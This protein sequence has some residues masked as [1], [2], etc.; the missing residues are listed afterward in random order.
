MVPCHVVN[1]ET[2][3]GVLLHGLWF[4]PKKPK[5]AIVWVHGLT[6]SA[7]AR[8]ELLHRL[9]ES[10]IGVLS[11]NNRGNGVVS[12]IRRK[13][14]P[15]L[16]IG[17]AREKFVD[18]V[19]DIDG[20]IRF[21]RCQGVKRIFLAG[22]STGCQ[23][24]V[25]WAAK[26]SGGK[27]AKGIILLAPVNDYAAEIKLQGK[28]RIAKAARTA[29]EMVRRGKSHEFLPAGVWYE[30]LE[31]QRFLSLYTSGTA[32]DVFPY[33]TTGAVPQFL[34]MVRAPMLAFF[35]ENEE[36]AD[37]PATVLKE[38]FEAQSARLKGVIVPSVGHSFK[39]GERAIVREIRRFV[40]KA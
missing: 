5:M 36:F 14:K 35:A 22:H 26:R 15:E 25:F 32:E 23:K 10:G 4:G 11:F 24:S 19:D 1:I 39:R 17:G 40:E 38:W 29:Q 30:L 3:N 6:S 34:K 2:P 7:F 8:L 13:N 21:T 16:K 9:A 18:C 28:A 37:R 27:G 12:R 33:A 31:A 20:A